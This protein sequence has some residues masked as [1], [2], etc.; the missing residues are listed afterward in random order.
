MKSIYRDALIQGKTHSCGCKQYAGKKG[1]NSIIRCIAL[2]IQHEDMSEAVQEN[3]ADNP[4]SF[5]QSQFVP[6][7]DVDLPFD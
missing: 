3:T 2:K 1:I 7:D 5:E 4:A 6:Y